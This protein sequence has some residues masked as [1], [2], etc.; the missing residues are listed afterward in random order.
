MTEPYGYDNDD[1]STDDNDDDSSD[2][3]VTLRRSQIRAMERDAKAARQAQQEAENLRRELALTKAGVSDLTE[4][5]QKSVL[6]NIDG[7][8]T[9]ESA[10]AV[11][12]EL[13]FV[14]PAAASTDDVERRQMEQMSQASAGASDPGSEDSIARLQRAAQEGGREAL[15]AQIQADG[16]VVAS[17]T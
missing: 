4:R 14:K 6:A 1:D 8:V 17:G 11:A 3:Q 2:R 15:L 7:D 5:Q 9:V 10:R 12:E 16:H 13:G